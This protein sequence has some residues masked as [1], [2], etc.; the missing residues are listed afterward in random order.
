MNP[1]KYF[2]NISVQLLNIGGFP[3]R[4]FTVNG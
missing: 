2:H 4:N 3:L 1:K